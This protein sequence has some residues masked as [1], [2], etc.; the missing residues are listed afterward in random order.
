MSL[1]EDILKT[2]EYA[3]SFGCTLNEKQ[4]WER[5]VGP[6]IHKNLPTSKQQHPL[7]K[8]KFNTKKLKKAK[9]LALLLSNKFKNILFIGV[10][11]SV[12]T[13]FPKKNDDIDLLV[14]VKNNTLWITRFWVR[15][16]VTLSK[17]PHRKFGKKEK[18]DEFCFN[19][20]LDESVLK[21]PKNKQNLRNAVDL[22]LM[23]KIFDQ[24]NTYF[25]FI[26]ANGWAKKYV[27]TPYFNLNFSLAAL[28]LPLHPYSKKKGNNFFYIINTL[29][30]I[31]QYIFM[32]FKFKRQKVNI[33]KAMWGE[34]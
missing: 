32:L 7:T 10:T 33:H 25:K 6:T 11:G 5:L 2:I 1:K 15:V 4:I 27:A 3:K 34:G 13:G 30:F 24:N 28:N 23:K 14:I 8:E 31:P 17:I 29:F 21:L 26:K 9:T 20:W 19:I 18:K 16:F 22:V 12:A